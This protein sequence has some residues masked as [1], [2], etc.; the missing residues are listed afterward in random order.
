MTRVLL[1]FLQSTLSYSSSSGSDSGTMVTGWQAAVN[2]AHLA[3]SVI[4][5]VASCFQAAA[6]S[7]GALTARKAAPKAQAASPAERPMAYTCYLCGQQYSSSSL[8]IHI[9]SCQVAL[10]HYRQSAVR[11]CPSAHAL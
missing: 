11:G 1:C 9:P 3:A 10:L 4:A 2:P 8:Y 5:N 6:G 7:G